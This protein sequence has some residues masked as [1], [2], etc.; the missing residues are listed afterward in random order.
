MPLTLKITISRQ[1]SLLLL[2]LA[3]VFLAS[4]AESG[5]SSK[6]RPARAHWVTGFTIKPQPIV[7][8]TT[9][10]GTIGV[11]RTVK[12][13]S[14]EEGEI[15][16]LSVDKGDRVEKNALLVKIEDA[17]IVALLAKAS[18]TRE[19][20]RQNMVRNQRLSRRQL[21]S[22]DQLIKAQTS[23][24]IASADE[25]LLK[26]RVKNTKISAPFSGII[27]ERVADKG[28]VVA[29]HR[30]ILTLIDPA[31]YVIKVQISELLIPHY[32]INDKV[33]IQIDALGSKRFEGR[34][35]RIHPTID[36]ATRQGTLEIKMQTNPMGVKTGQLCR[37]TLTSAPRTGL[38]IPF[39]SLRRDKDGEF[40]FLVVKAKPRKKKHSKGPSPDP[41]KSGLSAENSDSK[42]PKAPSNKPRKP[43]IR[44]TVKRQSVR[45]GL[46]HGTLVEIPEGLVTGMTVVNRGFLGLRPGK[47]VTVVDPNSSLEPDLKPT[48]ESD[49]K[50]NANQRTQRANK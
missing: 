19:Q 23:F 10:T 25:K 48:I 21:V 8:T 11:K 16:K 30:H 5:K 2:L 26:I 1:H 28:D 7:L 22:A 42:R 46:R 29:K 27:T 9:R 34:I 38:S 49:R 31:T 20:A 40:V 4:C 6:K 32:K 41:V 12:L 13:F 45:S 18:A 47:P 33:D 50:Q 3:V 35:I 24:K 36:S 15:T 39:N 37:V 14:Q 44:L 43:I 17:L